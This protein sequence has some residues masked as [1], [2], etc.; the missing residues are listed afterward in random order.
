MADYFAWP[1]WHE[2]GDPCNLDP[3]SL[4]I[5][6]PLRD[7][8]LTWTE[9]YNATFDMDDPPLSG[10]P[11]PAAELAFELAGRQLAKDLQE[12]LGSESAV[13]YWRD[14]S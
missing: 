8:L 11:S 3:A 10:F 2:G 9:E 5:T 12:E 13:R 14:P 4:L 1:V 6:K 7:R